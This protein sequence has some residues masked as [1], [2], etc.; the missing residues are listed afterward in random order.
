MHKKGFTL[1]ELMVVIAIIAI[2]A[3]VLVPQVFRRVEKRKTAAVNAFY[4]SVKLAVLAYQTDLGGI[5]PESCTEATCNTIAGDNGGF[6]TA[7]TN[8][9]RWEGPYID[10]WPTAGG[11]PYGGNY[12]WTAA[13]GTVFGATAVGERY[14]TIT[15]VP[16]IGAT[17][18]D[19]NLDHSPIATPQT[20][21]NIGLVRL[22]PAAAN[23]PNCTTTPDNVTIVVLV[24][25]DGPTN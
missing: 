24:S 18:I 8:N 11:N 6:V 1:I 9:A 13:S 20:G 14:I 21:A 2:L 22:S 3:I 25:R 17:R 16:C 5:W 10:R 7:A 19:R 15:G 12:Q 4:D 23:W